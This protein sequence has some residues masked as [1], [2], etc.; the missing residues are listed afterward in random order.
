M[1]WSGALLPGQGDKLFT[2]G[3]FDFDGDVDTADLTSLMQNWTGAVGR[4]QASAF[5]PEPSGL[6][7][8]AIAMV[9]LCLA[10]NARRRQSRVTA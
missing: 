8:L 10:A 9:L 7:G 1:N 2:D 6:A 3:D 5:V 4:V